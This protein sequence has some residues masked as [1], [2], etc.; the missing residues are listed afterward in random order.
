MSGVSR[1]NIGAKR[2]WTE[3]IKKIIEWRHT[4]ELSVNRLGAGLLCRSFRELHSSVIE[5][6][7]LSEM[8]QRLAAALASGLNSKHA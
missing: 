1:L 8:L 3:A 5:S 6:E 2:N 7:H 4:F